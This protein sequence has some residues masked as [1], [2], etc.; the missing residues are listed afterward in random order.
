MEKKYETFTYSEL[1]QEFRTVT[2]KTEALKK[3][4]ILEMAKRKELEGIKKEKVATVISA[5]LKDLVSA[6]YIRNILSSSGH[7]DTIKHPNKIKNELK[8]A[9]LIAVT[10]GGQELVPPSEPEPHQVITNDDPIDL[11]RSEIENDI[12]DQR[13]EE[14]KVQETNDLD[15][16][17]DKI[18]VIRNLKIEN[19]NLAQQLGELDRLKE[20]NTRLLQD[21]N[22]I[23][24]ENTK[25]KKRIVDLEDHI[26]K[27][28]A[29]NQLLRNA[30]KLEQSPIP[31]SRFS[32]K[33]HDDYNKNKYY[34]MIKKKENVKPQA[35]G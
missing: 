31:S 22:R 19:N 24:S 14:Q 20:E 8:E 4:L 28:K 10:P 23:F 18:H 26:T 33:S 32:T 11:I 9:Q 6:T 15:E 25:L 1:V 2:E 35:Q 27:L 34:T 30:P 13:P 29:E 16:D 7:T 3:D 17:I 12:I 21:Y 5:D